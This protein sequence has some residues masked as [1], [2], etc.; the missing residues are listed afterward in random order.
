MIP[1]KF[2]VVIEAWFNVMTAVNHRRPL[3]EDD[4]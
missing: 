1:H 2:T 4:G 3:V